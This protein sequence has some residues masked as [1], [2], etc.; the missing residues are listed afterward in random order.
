MRFRFVAR[1]DAPG[2]VVEAGVDD[3]SIVVY[4][5]PATGLA[6]LPPSIDRLVLAQNVPNPFGCE[7]VIGFAVPAPGREVT[8]RVF[9]VAGR[10]VAS[11]LEREL[12][13]GRGSVGWDGRDSA[14]RRVA[15][16]V[17]FYRLE[18]GEDLLS[19]KLVLLR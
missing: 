3:F 13:E 7:T 6:D 16:G 17:Y 9:D 19:R 11:L 8:V 5:S 14:G 12:V 1:D 15:A 10:L 18:T 2:S 4:E